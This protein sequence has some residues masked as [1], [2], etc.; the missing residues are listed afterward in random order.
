MI[1]SPQHSNIPD[2][3]RTLDGLLLT[4][5]DDVHPRFFGEKLTKIKL[6]LSPDE[7]TIFELK[8]IRQFLK[9]NRPILGICLGCQMLNISLGGKLIQDLKSEQATQRNHRKGN[10]FVRI[11]NSSQLKGILKRNQ[12]KVN[13]RHHQAIKSVGKGL[14]ISAYSTDGVIE[15]IEAK[16][17]RYLIGI[18]WH[19]EILKDPLSKK[20]FRSFIQACK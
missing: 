4:G 18:Q 11:E 5:G 15:G 7:R 14:K 16:N 6:T 9:T 2:Y 1:L 13:S 12:C 19:P 3:V 8:L 10:H 17:S 20:L